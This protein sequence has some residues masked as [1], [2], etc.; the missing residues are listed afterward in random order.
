MIYTIQNL[1]SKTYYS[2]ASCGILFCKKMQPNG[3]ACR[4][5]DSVKKNWSASCGIL[6]CKKMQ[7]NGP[8]RRGKTELKK[9]IINNI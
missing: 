5:Y 6:F 7:P 8:A 4:G 9:C 3:P 2:T 1:N